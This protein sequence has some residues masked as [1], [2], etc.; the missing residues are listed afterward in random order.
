MRELALNEIGRVTIS[1]AHPVACERY[2]VSR[3]LGGFI[4]IDRLTRNTVGA[5]MVT[6]LR[7]GASDIHWHRLD[8]DKEARAAT[9]GPEAGGAVVHR[10][11]GRRQIHHRQPGGKARCTR[12]AAT[13]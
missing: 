8:V 5:G 12:R 13:P 10:P 3:E 6:D 2:A 7:A 1:L 11:V 4:L 9:E